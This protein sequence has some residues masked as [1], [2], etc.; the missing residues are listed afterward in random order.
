MPALHCVV[1]QHIH[2]QGLFTYF[3]L[4]IFFLRLI[5][6]QSTT[7]TILA[8]F[9]FQSNLNWGFLVI[10]ENSGANKQHNGFS[11]SFAPHLINANNGV[12]AAFQLIFAV[13]S[14][15]WQSVFSLIRIYSAITAAEAVDATAALLSDNSVSTM[16]LNLNSLFLPFIH[17]FCFLLFLL[18]L[19]H[20]TAARSN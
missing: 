10:V 9:N 4:Q 20:F 12:C 8:G 18:F 19:F 3:H 7:S 2:L 16:L 14:T 15:K 1:G 13:N 17:S 6:S 5:S 11:S